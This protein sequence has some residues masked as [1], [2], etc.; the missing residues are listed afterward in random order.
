MRGLRHKQ[1]NTI[2]HYIID[3][4]FL[5]DETNNYHLIIDKCAGI[6]V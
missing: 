4:V 3:D 1:W 2:I 6:L 5:I